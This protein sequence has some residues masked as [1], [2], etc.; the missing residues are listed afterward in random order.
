MDT[1]NLS[2][3]LDPI[4]LSNLQR[5]ETDKLVGIKFDLQTAFAQPETATP[6]QKP[7]GQAGTTQGGT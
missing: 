3:T 2:P 1:I 4:R 6:Q 5:V 7:A